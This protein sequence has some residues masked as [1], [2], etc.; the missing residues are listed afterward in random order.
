MSSTPYRSS[1]PSSARVRG[2][3]DF[4][5]AGGFVGL[6]EV[7]AGADATNGQVVVPEAPGADADPCEVFHGIADVRDLPVEDGA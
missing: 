3:I 1:V 6:P 5:A 2:R 4:V 7:L